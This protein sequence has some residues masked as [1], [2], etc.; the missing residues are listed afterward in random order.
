MGRLARIALPL[1]FASGFC[2]LAYQIGWQREFRGIFGASTAA[3]AAVVAV[4]MGGL[5]LGGVVLGPRA[6]RHRNPLALYALLEGLVA[7]FAA[8]T[9]LL[10][11]LARRAYLGLGGSEALGAWG[12]TALRLL[13]AALVLLPPTFLAGGTLGAAARAVE[14][15]GDRRRRGTALLY[16]ANTLGAVAGGLCATFWALEQLG[17]RATL[18]AAA[19]LNLAVAGAAWALSRDQAAAE[20]PL[21]EDEDRE[22]AAPPG[23]VLAAAA[24]VGFAFFLMEL[25]WYRMLS[26]ILGGTVYTFGLVLAIA[27]LGI[28]IGGLVY[29]R[30]LARTAIS[31]SA[32]A[33]SCLAEAAWVALPW[34]MGDRI[35]LLALGLRPEPGA[36]LFA[37][38]VGWSFVAAIVVLPASIVAGAQFPLLIALLGGGRRR[39]ASHVGRAYFFNTAGAIVGALAGGFGLLPLLTA[40]GCW[41]AVAWLLCG[42]GLVA[43]A[44]D[45][46]RT[47]MASGGAVALALV[48]S[49][50][51]FTAGGPSAG[52]RHSGIGAGRSG[53]PAP[54][55]ARAIEAWL[56]DARRSIVWEREGVESSVALQAVAG[57][58]FLLNGK[59]DGNARND[60]PTQVM[61]GLLG[62]LLRPGARSSLVIG[63]GT[64]ST[65]G[66][67]AN[68]PG[69]ERTDVIE[70]EPAVVEVARLCA[71]VNHNALANP[72]VRVRI[73]DAREAL[74]TTRGRWDL[75]LSE[76]SNPYRAGIASL[77]TREFYQAV[78]DRLSEDGLFLQWLQAYE[79]DER[80]VSTILASM[81]AVFEAVEV[82]QV[83]HIDMVLVGSHRPIAHDL[84]GLRARM[85]QE[86]FA[87]AL[88]HAW[89][90]TDVHDLLARFVAGPALARRL[91]DSGHEIN[92]DDRNPVE[93]AFARTASQKGLFDVPQLRRL[94]AGAGAD[95]L[96]LAVDWERV[97]RRR[98]DVYT[99]AGYAAP[100]D[101]QASPEESARRKAHAEYAAG[102]IAAAAEAFPGRVPES[103]VETMLLAEGL[104]EA[105]STDAR[106]H[107]AALSR[108]QKTEAEAATASLAFRMGLLELARNALAASFVHYR[109][110]P[111]PSQVSMA[112]A[113]GLALRIAQTQP[114]S[115]P[116]LAEALSRPFAVAALEEPRRLV[117]MQLVSLEPL[118]ERCRDALADLE[119]HVPWRQDV[120][121]FRAR[122]Y[123]ATRDTRAQ[124]A[125]RD[126][127]R[128]LAM[129]ANTP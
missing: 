53:G 50:A 102:N 12:G 80:T 63:L 52:W 120:L 4:F 97:A 39:L 56:R 70:L 17:T 5:G 113:L 46:R 104:S 3:S 91:R 8:T 13:L 127:L 16:G 128:F 89:R 99:L 28:A 30:L 29:S 119:P 103:V 37:Y 94:A 83:H 114:Q 72:R 26:P 110:D 92:T 10:L 54:Q 59:V 73:G 25:V 19:L 96:D 45:K 41:R 21:H 116:I 9:P 44:L 55:G 51:L 69:M 121:E 35:A 118:S 124:G 68:V 43:V 79:V 57:Y 14:S 33:A 67:L 107:L 108:V 117:R 64:G 85:A 109:D 65:A 2:A 42:L 76:P 24:L 40:P 90:A 22:P 47:L 34:V 125:A 115:A 6:D 36:G 81:A 88:R 32:L 27:L 49:I 23:L 86:P 101:P 78:D 58:S 106:P 7:L 77:F 71:P 112:Q 61:S 123:A 105:G 122:C 129:P 100:L 48:V 66:W 93:F 82:W 15:E 98:L 60:A 126:L 11:E 95:R 20:P 111:W 84:D 31:L 18:W 87:E 62:P 75:V 1:V 74:M 38:V